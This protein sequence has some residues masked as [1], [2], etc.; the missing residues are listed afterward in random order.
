MSS[1]ERRQ[2]LARQ[3]AEEQMHREILVNSLEGLS[4]AL[5]CRDSYTQ[6]HSENV[7]SLSAAVAAELSMPSE[8]IDQLKL[9]ARVHDIGKIGVRDD[10]LLEPGKLS[11]DE[12]RALEDHPD[13]AAAILGAIPGTARIAD[14]VRSH[15]ECPDGSG[16]PRGLRGDN[17][18]TEARILRVADMYSALTEDRP[19]HTGVGSS[20]AMSMIE[21]LR[22]AEVDGWAADGLRRVILQSKPAIKPLELRLPSK[23]ELRGSATAAA[24]LIRIGAE[25]HL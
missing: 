10:V 16:Y 17:I 3:A 25:V 18:P 2:R 9:A 24:P 13:V 21:E 1:L 6:E 8:S 23:P 22:G 20:E 5:K 11:V 15:H 4:G 14:I 19:Y 12:R 7:A